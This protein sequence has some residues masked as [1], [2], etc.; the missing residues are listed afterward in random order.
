VQDQDKVFVISVRERRILRVFNTPKGAG[1][2][3]VIPL[4]E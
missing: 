2:D 3:P 4:R 1:P